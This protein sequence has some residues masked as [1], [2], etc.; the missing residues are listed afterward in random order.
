[1]TYQ[2]PEDVSQLLS[3]SICGCIPAGNNGPK[4]GAG[5]VNFGGVHNI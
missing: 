3:H 4:G 5:L 1:M 2:S